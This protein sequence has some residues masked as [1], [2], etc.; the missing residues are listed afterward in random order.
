MAA[1]LLRRTLF[2]T[3]ALLKDLRVVVPGMGDSITEGSLIKLV[4]PVGS[5][6]KQDDI[7]CVIET[8]KVRG[9]LWLPPVWHPLHTPPPF[10]RPHTCPLP[11]HPHPTP[12]PMMHLGER[13]RALA[14]RWRAQ[15]LP[16]GPE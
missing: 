6:V 8:D 15:G 14:A 3:R 13:G 10:R 12:L 2:T 5:F 1:I 16:R 11:P 7:V 9:P 4:A